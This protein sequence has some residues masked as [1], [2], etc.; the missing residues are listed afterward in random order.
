M[1]SETTNKIKNKLNGIIK[2]K[3]VCTAKAITNRVKRQPTEWEK[4]L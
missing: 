2:G 4:Y 3:G 1:T